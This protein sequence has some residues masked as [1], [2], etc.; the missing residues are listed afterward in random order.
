MDY[1]LGADMMIVIEDQCERM[2]DDPQYLV[3]KQIAGPLGKTHQVLTR[4]GEICEK[5][6]TK[7]G[8]YIL[9][10]MGKIIEEND[11][12][13]VRVVELIPNRW[14]GAVFEEIRDE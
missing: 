3:N 8:L 4:L 2:F 5:G 6:L 11:R 7:I 12:V 9:Y 10:S 1:R 14:A 13:G